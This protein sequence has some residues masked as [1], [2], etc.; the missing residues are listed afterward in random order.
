MSQLLRP[1]TSLIETYAAYLLQL[2]FYFIKNSANLPANHQLLCL[3]ETLHEC[4]FGPME[5]LYI[6]RTGDD[7]V[8]H[9]KH[10][11]MTGPFA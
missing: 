11:L 1:I 8:K 5:Y 6:S 10:A 2:V 9:G 3:F 7:W 4:L